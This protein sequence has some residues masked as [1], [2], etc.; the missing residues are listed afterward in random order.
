MRY[1]IK[2]FILIVAIMLNL[3]LSGCGPIAVV[4]AVGNV[5]NRTIQR[6]QDEKEQPYLT[7]T[8][9]APDSGKVAISNLNVGVEYLRQ[10]NYERALSRLERARDADPGYAPVYDMLGLLHQRMGEPEKAEKNFKHA[11][12]LDKDNAGTLN[13]YGQFLCSE[14]REIEAEKYFR[15]AIANPLYSTPE[16]PYTNLGAC[17]YRH[18]HIDEAVDYFDKALSLNPKV[19]S[20]LI[21]LSEIHYEGGDYVKAG[22]YLDRYNAISRPSPMSLWLGIRIKQELGDV[23]SVSSYAL[24]L[25]NQFPKSDEAQLLK[26]SG[27]K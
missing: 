19:P 7:D 11:L 15:K 14:N 18:G 2:S 27:I 21:K 12:K 8:P 25:R 24:L 16:V 23:D 10:G 13:N 20:A 5:V 26:E 9:S 1:S 3:L 4:G 22:Q 6:R 17:V